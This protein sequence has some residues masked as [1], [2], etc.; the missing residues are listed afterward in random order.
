MLTTEV[1]KIVRYSQATLKATGLTIFLTSLGAGLSAFILLPSPILIL[2]VLNLA[3]AELSPLLLLFNLLTLALAVRFCRKVIP[4]ALASVCV[5][6]YP[7]YQISAVRLETNRPS[8]WTTPSPTAFSVLSRCVHSISPRLVQSRRL[9]QNIL[10]YP[11]QQ[12]GNRE[13]GGRHLWRRLAA[14]GAA[15]D[16][17]QFDSYLAL[18]GFAVFAIDY[19]H[20]PEF[21]FPRRYKTCKPHCDSCQRTRQTI[22][23][24]RLVSSCVADQP[25]RN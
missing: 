5:A 21:R 13:C 7:I 25:A 6:A 11:P 2:L 18:R 22:T 20:A 4:V 15:D 8:A 1:A 17:A 19:R 24:I 23:S 14:R 12:P 10:F 16:T 3:A 9:P